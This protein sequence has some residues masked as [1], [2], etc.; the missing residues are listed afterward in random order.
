MLV[1][2]LNNLLLVVSL[3]SKWSQVHSFSVTRPLSLG[4]N[5]IQNNYSASTPSK[6]LHSSRITMSTASERKNVIV[7]SP[8]GGIGEITATK[9]AR[10]G[11]TVRWFVV[12]PSTSSKKIT[13]PKETWDCIK[14]NEGELDIAGGDASSILL[15]ESNPESIVENVEQWCSMN[16]LASAGG[17]VDA[18]VVS[19]DAGDE[20]EEDENVENEVA[21]AVKRVTQ[22]TCS[23]LAPSVKRIEVV[24]AP[25]LTE[26]GSSKT[27]GD[28][29]SLTNWLSKPLSLFGGKSITLREA[30]SI[31]SSPAEDVNVLTLRH[32]TLFGTPESSVSFL[33]SLCDATLRWIAAG[34]PQP[35]FILVYSFRSFPNQDR[36]YPIY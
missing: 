32:C 2:S 19:L 23:R 24:P 26:D 22:M 13:F 11:N 27:S 8:S 1:G 18:V 14:A 15:P 16:A 31:S 17:N 28:E 7:V 29:G 25:I 9:L 35:N 12:D 5:V 36:R 21:N 34:L 3:W 30:M 10:E 20:A 4:R 33:E 6:S